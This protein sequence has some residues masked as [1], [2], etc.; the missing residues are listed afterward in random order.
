MSEYGLLNVEDLEFEFA[1]CLISQKGIICYLNIGITVDSWHLETRTRPESIIINLMWFI[2]DNKS[3]ES[4][5][6]FN[7]LVHPQSN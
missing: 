7:K 3:R 6:D 5:K 1:S 2:C 4:L